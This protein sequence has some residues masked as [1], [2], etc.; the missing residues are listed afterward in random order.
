[1]RPM[2]RPLWSCSRYGGALPDDD[3]RVLGVFPFRS[4]PDPIIDGDTVAVT[5]LDA[6]LRLLCLDAE[7]T[8]HLNDEL[9]DR[10]YTD[11]ADYL[12]IIYEDRPGTIPK[13]ATPGSRAE[14]PISFCRR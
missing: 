14:E 5:G 1:M 8:F 11:F 9:R 13:F 7:E 4:D 3:P 2:K 6:S 10:A 12:R